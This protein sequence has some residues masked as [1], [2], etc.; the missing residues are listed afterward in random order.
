MLRKD[1]KFRYYMVLRYLFLGIGIGL[2]SILFVI[3]SKTHVFLYFLVLGTTFF[4]EIIITLIFQ[5]LPSIEEQL[6]CLEPDF[7]LTGET[8]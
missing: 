7:K 2:A 5:R 1:L 8:K 6:D 3:F 4:F